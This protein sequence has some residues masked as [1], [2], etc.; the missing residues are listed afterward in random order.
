MSDFSIL[1]RPNGVIHCKKRSVAGTCGWR[2]LGKMWLD[3]RQEVRGLTTLRGAES[4][5]DCSVAGVGNVDIMIT[6]KDRRG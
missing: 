2:Q 4:P 3:F 5:P 6:Y 1:W